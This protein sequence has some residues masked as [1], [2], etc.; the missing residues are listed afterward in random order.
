MHAAK[1]AQV[2]RA[3]LTVRRAAWNPET[4]GTERGIELSV[5]RELNLLPRRRVRRTH[6]RKECVELEVVDERLEQQVLTRRI[7]QVPSTYNDLGDG[8]RV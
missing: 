3:T 1:N 5:L 2:H 6:A 7:C 4:L 8:I